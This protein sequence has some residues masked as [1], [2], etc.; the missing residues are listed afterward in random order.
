[1]T[2]VAMRRSKKT[3]TEPRTRLT[4]NWVRVI[5]QHGDP[6]MELRWAVVP[7]VHLTAA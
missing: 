6:R 5:D 7:Y 4:S 1:M 2:T 3:L